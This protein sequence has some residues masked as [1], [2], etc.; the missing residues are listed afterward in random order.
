LGNANELRPGN[1]TQNLVRAPRNRQAVGKERRYIS[2]RRAYG[3]VNM[4]LSDRARLTT[5]WETLDGKE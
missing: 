5:T 4:C 1:I 2:A 3:P